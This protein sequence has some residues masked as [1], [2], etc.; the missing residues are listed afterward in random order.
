M[1]NAE[2]QIHP[3]R[4]ADCE[5]RRGRSF[6]TA[7]STIAVA[8]RAADRFE[9]GRKAF[10]SAPESLGGFRYNELLSSFGTRHPAFSLPPQKRVRFV[11]AR[12]AAG[13]S[14]RHGDAILHSGEREFGQCRAP[15]DREC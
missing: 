3:W 13:A 5:S 15:H 14:S 4:I 1:P 8:K 7:N 12:A 2:C 10:R 6:P 9:R 11:L